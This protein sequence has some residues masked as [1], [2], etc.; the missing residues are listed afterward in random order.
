MKK[1]RNY[2]IIAA[3]LI[4][5]AI[6]ITGC[7]TPG[8]VQK[9]NREIPQMYTNSMDT[10]N[11]ATLRWQEFLKDPHLVALI[12]TALANNQELNIILQEIEISRNE[13]GA[14]KGEYLPSVGLGGAGGV[15]K[16]GRYTSQGAN[17]ANTD[18]KPGTE[19]PEPLPDVMVGAFA[20]W[21][22]DIWHKL[23]NAKE[24]AVKRYLATIEGK[25]YMVTHLVAEIANE[26]YE[27]L[28]LDNQLSILQQNIELQ[29][30]ALRIVRLQKDAAKVTQLAVKRFEAQVL[31]T[32][33]MQFEVKQKIIEK[34]NRINFLVGRF[35][36]KV[37]RDANVFQDLVPSKINTGIPS[38]LLSNRPD[39][40]AAEFELAANKLDVKVAKANFYPSLTINAGL[41]FQAFNPAFL[42]QAPESLIYS[43]AGDIAGPLINR[44][45]IKA[46]YANANAKQLQSVY[47]YE[48]TVLNAY[49]EVANQMSMINNLEQRYTL[50]EQ[51]VAALTQSIEISNQLFNSARADYMEVLLTQ[52]D[53]LESRFELIETKMQQM[54]AMV[55]IYQ[56]LGGGWK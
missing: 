44:K 36:Q 48:R 11:S 40:S 49:I 32:R 8:I 51:E 50:K 24:S 26:Y 56:A 18:I 54:N 35:P 19:M 9:A 21:E 28:A 15:E 52:R 4:A 23:R 30:N 33:G 47:N 29:N 14:R 7:V 46:A 25:N 17:D 20:Q 27:L 5:V 37:E 42:V 39:I 41:G 55:N 16:V 3:A 12:D 43:L 31:R 45:A 38:Q 2:K 53:A 1:N 6:T 10:L 13:I 22:V 34:E